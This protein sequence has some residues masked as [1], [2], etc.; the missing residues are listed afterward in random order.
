MSLLPLNGALGHSQ[1]DTQS[2]TLFQKDDRD[3]GS[4]IPYGQE[5]YGDWV[6]ELLWAANEWRHIDERRQR[7]R[8]VVGLQRALACEIFREDSRH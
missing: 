5:G 2:H 6:A 8:G 3:Q 4:R 1:R 7:G